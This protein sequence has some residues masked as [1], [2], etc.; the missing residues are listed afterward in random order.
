M[1]APLDDTSNTRIGEHRTTTMARR[2]LDLLVL[3]FN[4]AKTMIDSHVFAH[5]LQTALTANATSLPEMVVFSLQEV[6]P[7]SYAFIGGV[8]LNPFLARY[9]DALNLAVV[10]IQSTPP[11]TVAATTNAAFGFSTTENASDSADSGEEPGPHTRLLDRQQQSKPYTLVRQHNV[12]MTAIM[13]FARDPS[14]VSRIELAEVGFGTMD[15]GNKGAAGVRCLY[16][17]KEGGGRTTQLTFVATHLAPMEWNLRRRNANWRTICSALL[18]AEPTAVIK[19]AAGDEGQAAVAAATA[20]AA[21]SA[22]SGGRAQDSAACKEP[23]AE[24]EE[25][26]ERLLAEAEAANGALAADV[27]DAL[28]DI[29]IFR[30]GSHLFLAGDLNYRIS[31]R[32]PQRDEP[33]PRRAARSRE[34]ATGWTMLLWCTKEGAIALGSLAVLILSSYWLYQSL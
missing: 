4:A 24:E 23:T 12:G 9:E 33:F 18:F 34:F 22:M 28:H 8:F 5:H 3:T 10:K 13:V 17:D 14:A 1:E 19:R 26:A 27:R 30:P 21:T 15:M 31:D 32:S 16:T 7:L 25:E 20:A 2:K 29:T 11:P 6:S